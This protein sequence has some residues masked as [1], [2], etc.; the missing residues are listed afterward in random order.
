MGRGGSTGAAVG[1]T[2]AEVAAEALR[3]VQT[4]DQ[5][6]GQSFPAI[7][8]PRGGEESDATSPGGEEPGGKKNGKRRNGK[9]KKTRQFDK[10]L[11]GFIEGSQ[12]SQGGGGGGRKT[13]RSAKSGDVPA[14]PIKK[15]PYLNP[16]SQLVAKRAGWEEGERKKAEQRPEAAIRKRHLQMLKA[17][18]RPRPLSPAVLPFAPPLSLLSHSLACQLNVASFSS[19]DPV[20][21][22]DEREA[23][24]PL[25]AI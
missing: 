6:G 1:S 7:N 23:S 14:P 3:R 11:Q 19:R 18:S 9:G 10:S 8:T 15:S 25:Q 12:S 4:G 16:P 13:D 17:V 22:R 20:G 21:W 2:N 5:E 24:A